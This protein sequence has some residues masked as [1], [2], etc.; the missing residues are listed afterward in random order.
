MST[1]TDVSA[2]RSTATPILRSHGF[3]LVC[4][5]TIVLAVGL[6]IA[7]AL[8]PAT[9][10]SATAAVTKQQPTHHLSQNHSESVASIHN[11]IFRCTGVL[12][13]P[14]WV[15]TARHCVSRSTSAEHQGS[16]R[17]D[18]GV[19]RNRA[20]RYGSAVLYRD[21]DIALLRLNEPVKHITPAPLVEPTA[22]VDTDTHTLHGYG[23]GPES[24]TALPITLAHTE[25]LD[26]DVEVGDKAT[27]HIL[28]N[29]DRKVINGDSG[30]PIYDEHG[31]VHAIISYTV[32]IIGTNFLTRKESVTSYIGVIALNEQ[33][34]DWI[35]AV[36]IDN[37]LDERT[38]PNPIDGV[39]A[40]TS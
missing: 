28:V 12:I 5:A 31:H 15:L 1:P 4:S 35:N 13:D 22:A 19:N 2:P 3:T 37:L 40:T 32:D 10:V 33:H 39:L 24:D 7:L 16:I 17:I 30:S 6:I 34:H 8:S 27:H 9:R 38:R 29:G 11:D 20:L 36:V 18:I 25:N 26:N 14:Q 23:F 21:S